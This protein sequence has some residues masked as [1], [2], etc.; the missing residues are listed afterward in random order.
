M[1]QLAN[2]VILSLF[3]SVATASDVPSSPDLEPVLIPV[4]V[5]EPVPG[6]HGSEWA[7]FLTI[8][9][10]GDLPMTL[11]NIRAESDCRIATWCGF[12]E[13]PPHTSARVAIDFLH[14]LVIGYH[15]WVEESQ[16]PHLSATL[17]A[18]DLSRQAQTWGTSLPV[19]SREDWFDETFSFVDV[20]AGEG[21]RTLLRLYDNGPATPDSVIVRIYRIDPDNHA[22]RG[23][24]EDTL[25]A[26]QSISL[27]S[28]GD[29]Y[30]GFASMTID[31]PAV[32]GE[33]PS[34]LRVDVEP[35][36]S[37]AEFWGMIT[38]TNNETQHI[39]LIMP[40]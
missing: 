31:I 6:A 28:R 17:R 26:Q 35:A 9:N 37:G 40:E 14:P 19:T 16:L 3:V 32:E 8:S 38:T 1:T 4:Y 15:I 33:Q 27:V 30:P 34:L 13:L 22:P 24:T 25:V 2:V 11:E 20:P 10:T 39:T 18:Q 23:A 12:G 29:I 36:G 7:T 5:E 21:F